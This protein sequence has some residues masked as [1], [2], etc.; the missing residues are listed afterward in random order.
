MQGGSKPLYLLLG[1]GLGESGFCNDFESICLLCRGKDTNKAFG[2]ASLP[3]ELASCKFVEAVSSFMVFAFLFNDLRYQGSIQHIRSIHLSRLRCFGFHERRGGRLSSHGPSPEHSAMS[4]F[5]LISVSC[6]SLPNGQR[7]LRSSI[8]QSIK[9]TLFEIIGCD[10][11]F[12][13]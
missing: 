9:T 7:L 3:Q 6:L 11:S 1:S 12:C 4:S 13:N 10:S 5:N 8:H 2:K